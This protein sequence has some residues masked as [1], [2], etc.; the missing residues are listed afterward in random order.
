MSAEE[1]I[2]LIVSIG[3]LAYLLVVFFR[4]GAES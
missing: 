2:A 1:I 4:E 3:V